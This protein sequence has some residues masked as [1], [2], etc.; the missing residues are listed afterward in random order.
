[1]NI[2]QVCKQKFDVWWL[3]VLYSTVS[4][5]FITILYVYFV[6]NELPFFYILLAEGIGY[7]GSV[8]VIL[9]KRSFHSRRDIQIGLSI[10]LISLLALLLPI[11]TVAILIL[12]VTLRVIGGILFF[13]PYNVLF[14][15]PTDKEKKLYRMTIYWAIGSVV[16]V[17]APITTGF[18]FTQFGLGVF[19]SVAI[20]L[21]LIT[22]AL[23]GF[24][25]KDVYTYST[26]QVLSQIR[27]LRTITM[28]DGALLNASKLLIA[29]YLITFVNNEFDF[30][31]ILSLIA[32]LSVVLSFKVAKFSDTYKKR[33]I[34]IFPFSAVLALIFLG[35]YVA[36][37]FWAVLVLVV[38]FSLFSSLFNPIRANIL[39]DVVENTPLTW[40]ARDI[41]L[42][43]G[44]C[45][46]FVCLAIV[47]QLDALNISFLLMSFL[48][49]VFPILLIKK[50]AYNNN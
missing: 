50:G 43:I 38:A 30:G 47:I 35:L 24:V 17:L 20:V 10:V 39:L 12:Y 42:N 36:Q 28:M 31:K 14:F 21:L 7:G 19:I 16:G 2:L 11:P 29:L 46:I 13:V 15:E 9:L 1:M 49:L 6:K 37:T 33:T 4:A 41:Y 26:T 22:I 25:K 5:G 48:F 34:F 44:R 32:V 27:G 23:A 3:Q 45:C 18:L 40:I 8:I